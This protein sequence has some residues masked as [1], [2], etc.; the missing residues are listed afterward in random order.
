MGTRRYLF[1][2]HFL[3]LYLQDPPAFIPTC[4][5]AIGGECVAPVLSN[6]MRKV[7]YLT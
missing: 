6:P 5:D 1:E 3:V 7:F 4:I 2:D